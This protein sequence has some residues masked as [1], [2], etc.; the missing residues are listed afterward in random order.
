MAEIHSAVASST[1]TASHE[2][3]R[4]A[5]MCLISHASF[6]TVLCSAGEKG[7]GHLQRDYSLS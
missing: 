4:T 3:R 7:R 2:A 6:P 1:R 5:T